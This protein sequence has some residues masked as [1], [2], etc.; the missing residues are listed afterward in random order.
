MI[1]Q[2]FVEMPAPFDPQPTAMVQKTLMACVIWLIVF[3]TARWGVKGSRLAK[4]LTRAEC[5]TW[6]MKF[7]CVVHSA[8]Q[9]T[10]A[11]Y[12]L[13]TDPYIKPELI[14]FAKGED[15]DVIRTISPNVALLLPI[16]L[17]FFLY[18]LVV[19]PLWWTPKEAAM[20]FH[21]VL[22][23]FLNL[24]TCFHT[25][26]LYFVFTE[27]ST[28]FVQMRWFIEKHLSRQHIA[29]KINAVVM[30][31]IFAVVRILPIPL[32]HLAMWHNRHIIAGLD[33]RFEIVSALLMNLPSLPNLYWAM[34]MFQ[35]VQKYRGTKTIQEV[36]PV[37][38]KMQTNSRAKRD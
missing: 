14:K 8:V 38:T 7:S 20:V 36:D 1:S 15:F 13:F 6:G 23:L 34:L 3:W 37:E 12:L 2:L 21:H 5:T 26:S 30:L 18:E 10:A 16:T 29:Y 4:D 25:L 31:F 9:S 33:T 17:G 28:P 19:L 32:Y 27:I 11:T 22:P 24:T 35:A